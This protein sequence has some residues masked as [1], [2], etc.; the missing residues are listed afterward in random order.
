[1]TE[2]TRL[3]FLQSPNGWGY[4]REFTDAP[5]AGMALVAYTVDANNQYVRR[6]AVWSH[7]T[8]IDGVEEWPADAGKKVAPESIK[9]N[10]KSAPATGRPLHTRPARLIE[11]WAE[12]H[13]ARPVI[14]EAGSLWQR[15]KRVVRPKYKPTYRG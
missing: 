7:P 1:M 9:P 13:H 15:I 11:R 5:P 2:E 12:W 10:K 14:V 8:A 3:V 6:W 4:W